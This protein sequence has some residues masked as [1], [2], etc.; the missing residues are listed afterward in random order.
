MSEIK[1]RAWNGKN[2]LSWEWICGI[3]LLHEVIVN[4]RGEYQ[5]MLYYK[6]GIWEGDIVKCWVK[7]VGNPTSI[8]T[9]EDGSFWIAGKIISKSYCR[10]VIG[11]RFENPEILKGIS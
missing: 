7:G 2:M 1:V 6:D 3:G 8:V 9:F 5:V 11:N 4:S 10:E